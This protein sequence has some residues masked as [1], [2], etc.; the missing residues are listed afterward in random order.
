MTILMV[1]LRDR[2]TGAVHKINGRAWVS[3][4]YF[5]DLVFTGKLEPNDYA[6]T[7]EQ[8]KI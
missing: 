2:Q 3:I 4:G 8:R 6:V 7:Y 5:K 1:Q